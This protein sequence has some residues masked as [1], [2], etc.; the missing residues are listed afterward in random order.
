MAK[1]RS[2][3]K[4]TARYIKAALILVS[5]AVVGIIGWN[6]IV[7]M[8]TEDSI[9][10]YS[11]YTAETG[12]ISTTLSFSATLDVKNT[13]TYTSN[14][15]TK[16]KEL[17]VA[18]GDEV[19]EGDPLVLLSNGELFTASF[20]GVVN[21]IRYSVGDW[22]RPMFGLIQICDLVN[23]EVTMEVDEYDV[24][25][26][27][28]GQ[29][30][31]VSVISLGIDFETSIGHINRVSAS[32]GT[33]A[34][35]TVTCNVTVPEEV[36][37]GMRAMVTIPSQSVENV[38]VLPL[39]ALTFD[40][41]EEAYTLTLN[42]DGTYDKV[43]VETGLSDGMHVEIKSGVN[44]GDTVYAA[45]GTQ[46][47]SAGFSLVD[48]YRAIAGEKVVINEESRQRPLGMQT[49]TEMDFGES[50]AASDD[51][52]DNTASDASES[53]DGEATADTGTTAI[54]DME[55][56]PDW[57][58]EMPEGFQ[59]EVPDWGGEMPEGMDGQMPPS[60]DFEMPEGMDGQMPPDMQGQTTTDTE[61]DGTDETDVSVDDLMDSET[62]TT[63]NNP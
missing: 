42:S 33:L 39:S 21:E 63:E 27:T 3:K 26:L 20:D 59:G 48:I 62:T 61:A 9:I 23:L 50:F 17:Y 6:Y 40:E 7:P 46:S 56:M 2:G 1:H 41:D 11:S 32:S 38:T 49:N 10:T 16:V 53:P 43:Y 30:C 60:G 29:T 8:L 47:A 12:D 15:M 19:E 52:S 35:Y 4:G 5:L 51:T 14:E 36:L 31:T 55:N 24:M 25:A 37:P 28:V 22:V 57:G 58:G 44:S 34:Y 45:D 54:P 13:Q 18:A